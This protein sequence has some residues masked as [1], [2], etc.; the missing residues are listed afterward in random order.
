MMSKILLVFFFVIT[1]FAFSQ[2]EMQ[3]A[4]QAISPEA[5]ESNMSFLANDLLEGRQP[6]TRGFAI[7]SQY[8]QSQFKF[9]GLKPGGNDSQYV[10]RVVLKKGI[11]D[12]SASGFILEGVNANAWSY[13]NEFVFSPYM[14]SERSEVAAPLIFAGFGISA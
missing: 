2:T 9:L 3:K 13:G 14:A 8:V 4:L 10:Q 7:A 11:V 5:I 1:T 12:R 6:G